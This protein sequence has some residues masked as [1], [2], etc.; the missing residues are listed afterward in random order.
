MENISGSDHDL[1]LHTLRVQ[2]IYVIQ[3]MSTLNRFATFVTA[4]N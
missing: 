4:N 3:R 1:A 2:T